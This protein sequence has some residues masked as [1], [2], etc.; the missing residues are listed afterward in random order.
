MNETQR[1]VENIEK[2]GT[3]HTIVP[4]QNKSLNG[5]R[6]DVAQNVICLLIMDGIKA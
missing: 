6:S 4:V 5:N 3:K 2:D 1:L